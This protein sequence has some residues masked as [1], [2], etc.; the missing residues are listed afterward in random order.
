MSVLG[1]FP[2]SWRV[3]GRRFFEPGGRP[4]PG[5][6]GFGAPAGEAV[7]ARMFRNPRRTRA[8]VSRPGGAGFFPGGRGADGPDP[9]GDPRR[10]EPA[11]RGGFLP[12]AAQ[13][14]GEMP[15]EAQLGMAGDDDPGPPVSGG[16]VADLR[17]GPAEDLLEQ[18]E[19]VLE[20]E[21]AQERLPEPVHVGRGR[22][23]A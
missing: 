21:T 16:G 8:G 4:G 9:A 7:F 23:G 22:A 15:G 2:T 20:I 1:F 12:G 19:G 17:G 11:R 6:P 5:L 13:I 18:P 14:A 10:G 3:A